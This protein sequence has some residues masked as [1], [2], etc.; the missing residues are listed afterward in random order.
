MSA[1]LYKTLRPGRLP[2]FGGVGRWPEP[3][4]WTPRVIP[5][6]CVSGWHVCP[7][8]A[9]VIRWAAP[10]LWEVEIDGATS[11]DRDKIAAE[12][13]RLVRRIDAWTREIRDTLLADIAAH[14]EPLIDP[15][16]EQPRAIFPPGILPPTGRPA[17]ATVY[18]RQ[19]IH[20]ATGRYVNI[21]DWAA[22]IHASQDAIWAHDAA[23]HGGGERERARQA[24]V[25]AGL[26]GIEEA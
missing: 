21:N 17:P 18:A 16:I 3:G 24:A 25:L 19:A 6:R 5:N 23:G 14:V 10:E 9:G 22:L 20:Y 2:A 8:L 7:D 12:R 26:L 4:K 15:D 1:T 11:G 13:A